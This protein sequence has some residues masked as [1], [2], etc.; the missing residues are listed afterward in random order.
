VTSTTIIFETIWNKE[1]KLVPKKKNI[2]YGK[3]TLNETGEQ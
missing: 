1:F 3:A 2:L